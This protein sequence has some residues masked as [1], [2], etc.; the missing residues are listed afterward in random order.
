MR[1]HNKTIVSILFDSRMKSVSL[2]AIDD[3]QNIAHLRV[4]GTIQTLEEHLRGTADL[5]SD[6]AGAIGMA[7]TGRAIGLLHDLGKATAAFNDY[8]RSDDSEHLRGSIDHSTAGA[9]FLQ[10]YWQNNGNGNKLSKVALEMMQL[11]IASHHSGL[12][13]CISSSGDDVFSRRISKQDFETGLNES[14]MRINQ[15]ILSEIERDI[16]A[17]LSSIEK[18]LNSIYYRTQSQS[19]ENMWFQYG[20]LNRFLL[21]CLI[22]ADRIDTISF[23]DCSKYCPPLTDWM[24]LSN[25]FEDAINKYSSDAPI[26]TIRRNI[27]DECYRASSR[28][29][30]I[31]TLSVPT[32][33]GK[34][35]SSF[36][37]ALNHLI[38]N[39]MSRIIYVVPYL[40]IL[41][42]NARVIENI[43]NAEPEDDYVTQ[44]HSN[45]DVEEHRDSASG[46]TEETCDWSS[47]MDVWDGPV[48]F[49]SMVQFLESLFG[50]G[51]K[52][53]RRMHNLAN[54]II[55]FDEIQN[56]P[57]KTVHMFNEAI[58]FLCHECGATAVLCTAT[59]P[60]L[61]K[62]DHHP[63][64]IDSELI[65]NVGAY[66]NALKRTEVRYV[67]PVGPE[68]NAENVADFI[69]SSCSDTPST[70]IIV[71]TKRMAKDLYRI[72]K[73]RAD[74]DVLV[75]HLSTNM[76]PVHR[77]QVLNEVI[78]TL[79]HRREICVSTQLIEAG[80][81]VDFDVVV[82]S[83]AGLDSIAQAAG[84]CNRNARQPTGKVLVIRMEESLGRLTDISEGRRC[85]E[86]VIR[87]DHADLVSP[88]AMKEYYDMFFFK[89]KEDMAYRIGK[90]SKTLVDLLAGNCYGRNALS[91]SKQSSRLGI[92]PQA[93][94][95][96]NHEFEVIDE[97]KG[98]VVPYDDV[99]R[100]MI[101]VLC[102][103]TSFDDRRHALRI[104][105]HYTVN[106]YALDHLIEVGAVTIISESDNPVYCLVEG[107]YSE[108]TGVED[109]AVQKPLIF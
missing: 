29:P 95:D 83:L 97:M 52:K 80:V 98:V 76:C 99:A 17:A 44:C 1:L 56:L 65:G 107:F 74:E 94:S 103:S 16:P 26:S 64:N 42:Q 72:L 84:R 102:G 59:Q 5:C 41:E 40:T 89:R 33:G 87:H 85:T 71:N 15:S 60:L 25:R 77:Y 58:N 51:T 73:S 81:D 7:E 108:E 4:D 105:Q 21:S 82:R 79:G 75:T 12:I 68:W 46:N 38:K 92:M 13:N 37:F 100:E 45:V 9:Q 22:D 39:K 35:L 55:V 88:E 93:F 20:L 34:T 61:N 78:T 50:P 70:L 86:I 66:F 109:V 31:F 10:E 27:S 104:L 43:L 30:G 67:N 101:S 91:G 53:I 96:A 6:F 36:R 28:R 69:I 11:T 63:L 23:Q 8:I 57:I 3:M 32:G 14:K 48:I 19:I 24:L 47:P 106:T 2:E 54:S 90:G 18:H 62:V 49:T